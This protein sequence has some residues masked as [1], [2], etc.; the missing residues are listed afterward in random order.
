M[1]IICAATILSIVGCNSVRVPNTRT[2]K[3]DSRVATDRNNSDSKV[4]TDIVRYAREQIGTPYKYAGRTPS[5]FDC[6]GLTLYVFN[7][8]DILLES[9]SSRQARMGK[10]IDVKNAKPGDL[11][12]FGINNI[13]HVGIIS[14]TSSKEVFMIHSSSSQGVIETAIFDST[15]WSKRLRF[16]RRVL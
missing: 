7:A 10:P 14:R 6:S 12:F 5:G 4:R 11:V 8:F 13:H 15:Y 16:A 2:P 3:T 1:G 9:S